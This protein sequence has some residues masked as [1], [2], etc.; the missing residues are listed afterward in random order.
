MS[1]ERDSRDCVG[2]C[3]I[4]RLKSQQLKKR[5]LEE[6]AR[7]EEKTRQA[8]EEKCRQEQQQK[9]REQEEKKQKE[10]ELQAQME[11][12][13]RRFRVKLLFSVTGQKKHLLVV[14]FQTS[15]ECKIML[16]IA[17]KKKKRKSIHPP[18]HNL[19]ICVFVQ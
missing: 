13:V 14:R 7:Q 2:L 19:F 15:E 18:M 8:E 5:Q 6:R 11:K 17:F 4:F 1:L 10:K 16:A 3:L 9:M 12:E